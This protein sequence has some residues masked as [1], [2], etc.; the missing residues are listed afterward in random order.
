[1]DGKARYGVITV[2]V[3]RLKLLGLG[4]RGSDGL[5]ICRYPLGLEPAVYIEYLSFWMH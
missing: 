3:H 5:S 4:T 2:R 1:M